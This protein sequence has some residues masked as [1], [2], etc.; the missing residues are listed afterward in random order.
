V[1][2]VDKRPRVDAAAEYAG[3]PDE[4]EYVPGARGHELPLANSILFA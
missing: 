3:D 2:S 4:R 1:Q